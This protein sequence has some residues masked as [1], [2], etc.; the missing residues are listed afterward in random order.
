MPSLSHGRL[1]SPGKKIHLLIHSSPSATTYHCHS[2]KNQIFKLHH[3]PGS[4]TTDFFSRDGADGNWSSFYLRVGTPGQAIRVLPSTAGLAI[5]AVSPQGCLPGE[6]GAIPGLTCAQSRGDLFDTSKSSS[7]EGVGNYTMGLERNLGYNDTAAFGLETV[8]LGL[9]NSTDRSPLKSQVVAAF[10]TDD[11]YMGLFGL[12]QQP[13][14]FSNFTTSYS[15]TL[16][17]LKSQQLIPSLTWGYTAGAY[18]RKLCLSMSTFPNFSI[19]SSMRQF[20]QIYLFH[21][22]TADTKVL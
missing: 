8:A 11:Y 1:P 18:Y 7:W 2:S 22:V 14:H 9:T 15:T 20:H 19:T 3:L 16:T 17:T 4:T 6:Y 10:D 21:Q 5:W 12:G 13:T